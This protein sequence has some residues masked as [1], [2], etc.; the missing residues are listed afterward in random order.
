MTA[1]RT[2]GLLRGGADVYAAAR[3]GGPTPHSLAQGAEAMG[4]A[5]EGT[6]AFLILEAAKPGSRQTHKL[7]PAPARA[8]AVELMLIGELLSREERFAAYGP[9][10]VFDLQHRQHLAYELKRAGSVEELL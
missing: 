9:Q 4:G 2:I 10:A 5:K 6:A 8:R 3:P 7:F 1:A